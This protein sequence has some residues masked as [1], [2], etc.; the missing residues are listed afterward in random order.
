MFSSCAGA[1]VPLQLEG[2]VL[3]P[4]REKG[5]GLCCGLTR[6]VCREE[7]PTPPGVVMLLENKLRL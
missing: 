3:F 4:S 2:A 6:N 1:Q 5:T 7:L